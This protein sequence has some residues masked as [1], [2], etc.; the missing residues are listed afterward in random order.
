MTDK[1]A[2]EKIKRLNMLH[3]ELLPPLKEMWVLACDL[4]MN[5]L[6]RFLDGVDM[7]IEEKLPKI[8]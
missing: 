4:K 6:A 7:G 5:E 8:D 2:V 1:E 3:V